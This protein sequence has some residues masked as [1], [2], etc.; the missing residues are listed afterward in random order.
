M[1]EMTDVVAAPIEIDAI[2]AIDSPSNEAREP[3]PKTPTVSVV[4]PTLNEAGNLPHVLPRIPSWVHELIVVDGLS[5][6]D[7]IAVAQAEAPQAKVLLVRTPGKGA[8]LRAGFAEAS[9]DI[10]VML[11]ADGSTD[12]QEIS[13]FVG[14]LMSGA[15]V[16]MGSRF[17][18]GGGTD[19]ME[20]HRKMGNWALT[21]LVRVGFGARF[22]DLCYGY[23]AFW[24]DVLPVLDGN[25]RGFEVETMLHIRAVRAGLRIAEV[26]SF[27]ASRISG[28]TNLRTVRDGFRVLKAITSEWTA[29]HV[30]RAPRHHDA[31]RAERRNTRPTRVPPWFHRSTASVHHADLAE[32][33]PLIRSVMR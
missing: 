30:V 4:I 32:P 14:L 5:R 13:A 11:D 17:S 1:G 12:P 33:A 3:F 18:M 10:I 28:T 31:L 16:A 21:R 19:D 22:S 24:R 2:D 29:E 15:D 20:A 6:D 23:T 26:P 9:G 25:F 8:A 7:T 27:E